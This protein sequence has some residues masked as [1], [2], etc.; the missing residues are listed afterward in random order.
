MAKDFY[1][2]KGPNISGPFSPDDLRQMLLRGEIHRTSPCRQG[3]TGGWLTVYDLVPC[4]R[5]GHSLVLAQAGDGGSHPA[6]ADR[7]RGRAVFLIVAV[8]CIVAALA[9]LGF[10]V[11]SLLPAPRL[12]P[13]PEEAMRS[14]ESAAASFNALILGAIML[15]AFLVVFIL[16]VGLLVFAFWLWMLITIL[17][18]EPPGHDKIV[19]TI[20]AIIIPPVGSLLYFFIRYPK[21]KRTTIASA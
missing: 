2:K 17:T 20:V 10:L 21:V 13:S 19:W 4:A 7:G 11:I 18:R 9:L 16:G 15:Q 3:E 6:T 12:F 1:L 8:V 5:W 14:P